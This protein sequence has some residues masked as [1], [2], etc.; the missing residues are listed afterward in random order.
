MSTLRPYQA[1]AVAD[2]IEFLRG[3]GERR[4][5]ASP[6]GTGK[7]YVL[8]S[9]L[10][11]VPDACL[12]TPRLEIVAS[13]L[14][15]RGVD[16]DRLSEQ[17]LVRLGIEHR[18]TT[19]MRARNY[20]ENGKLG[21]WPKILLIDE[22]HHSTALTYQELALLA[23]QQ[24]IGL[25]AT[26]YRGTP[27]GTREFLEFWGEPRWIITLAEAAA[28]GD[29]AFPRF[30]FWPLLDDDE[31]EVQGGEFKV[32]SVQAFSK[33]LFEDLGGRLA[34]F[35]KEGRWDRPTMLSVSSVALA[36]DAV[37][38]FERL[39]LPSV[40]VVGSTTRADRL[41]AFAR[42]V[43]RSALLVQVGVVSEGVDLPIRRLIDCSPT[44]SPVRWIQQLGRITRPSEEPPEC[45]VCCRNLERHAYLLDG[46]LPESV[47]RESQ[48][49]FPAASKRAASRVVG[50]E[51]IGRFRPVPIPLVERLTGSLYSMQ[52]IEG[53]HV[54]EYTIFLHPARAEPLVATRVNDRSTGTYGKWKQIDELPDFKG[55]VASTPSGEMSEKQAEWWRK[56]AARHGLDPDAKVNR[57]QFQALP[58]LSDL[59]ARI[60]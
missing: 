1:A 14:A 26:P 34:Q 38:T 36:T 35:F 8:S 12:V 9:I 52:R 20:L 4:C 51:R 55:G 44:M 59:K 10:D 13:I 2:A 60:K 49:A 58:V 19:P 21:W 31:I 57:K 24:M 25:T 37:R 22:V 7:S 50:L 41:E 29:L 28:R 11:A 3:G 17:R 5:Y 33:T 42:V 18:I 15:K 6:T 39:G 30:A 48:V 27:A 40:A 32:T 16:T 45:Y 53:H 56:A 46:V 43:D 54:H 23:G 47:V